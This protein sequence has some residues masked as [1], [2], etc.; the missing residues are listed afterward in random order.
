M[1]SRS[2]LSAL[3][4]S[5]TLR[6]RSEIGGS[7]SLKLDGP[8]APRR[9]DPGRGAVP[10]LSPSNVPALVAQAH[11]APDY[12]LSARGEL[13][14][15]DMGGVRVAAPSRETVV[16]A[17]VGHGRSHDMHQ[18]AL[19]CISIHRICRAN[20]T[21]SNRPCGPIPETPLAAS[22]GRP[23]ALREPIPALPPGQRLAEVRSHLPPRRPRGGYHSAENAPS[24][25]AALARG[26]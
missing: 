22:E 4:D 8:A 12:S 5:R 13:G 11:G 16:G 15:G 23:L 21:E 1:L 24:R 3:G 9:V 10:E 25:T 2:R 19:M 20:R 18:Y 6:G 26:G 7:R 17:S 14:R